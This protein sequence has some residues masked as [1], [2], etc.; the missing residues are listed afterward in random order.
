MPLV[1]NSLHGLQ[2]FVSAGSVGKRCEP[3]NFN[4][5]LLSW[6]PLCRLLEDEEL[7]FPGRFLSPSPFPRGWAT[8]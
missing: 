5:T 3:L 7:L 8:E 4:Y 6:L 1:T 2:L